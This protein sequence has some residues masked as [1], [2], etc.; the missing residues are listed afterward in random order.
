MAKYEKIITIGILF[1]LFV[2]IYFSLLRPVRLSGLRVDYKQSQLDLENLL[3]A[4]P[5]DLYLDAYNGKLPSTSKE[6]YVLALL[7]CDV[8]NRS[9]LEMSDFGY[10]NTNMG[11][12]SDRVIECYGCG[13]SEAER[14]SYRLGSGA[15]KFVLCMYVGGIEKDKIPEVIAEQVN[16]MTYK[17]FY[18][19]ELLG[20]KETT[21]TIHMN[22]DDV[23]FLQPE[24]V[25]G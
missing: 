25:E 23:R 4:D 5:N 10:T 9:I 13:L 24:E 17:A 12:Y 1:F 8:K 6:D 20:N 21:F 19:M 14:L 2:V 16:S 11:K 15:A 22:P 3:Y 7:Y 18:T